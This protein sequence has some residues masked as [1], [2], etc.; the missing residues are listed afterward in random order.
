MIPVDSYLRLMNKLLKYS[1]MDANFIDAIQE[2]VMG[3]PGLALSFVALFIIYR[4]IQLK[5]REKL[6]LIE[7]GMTFTILTFLD[8]Y[9]MKYGVKFV[10]FDN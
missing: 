1:D 3:L 9:L 6:A 5:N 10:S 8:S 2:P 7:K 4:A